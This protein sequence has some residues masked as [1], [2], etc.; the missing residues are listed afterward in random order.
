MSRHAAQRPDAG[1]E[2]H[3][4]RVRGMLLASSGV[5][6]LL[7]LGWA[8]FFAWRGDWLIVCSDAFLCLL[9]LHGARLVRQGRLRRAAL[10]LLP[11]LLL[12]V[13]GYALFL[14]LPTAAAPRTSHLYLLPIAILS[15]VIFRGDKPL[16]RHGLP[17]L[18]LLLF[19]LLSA[20]QFGIASAH[21]LPDSLR[22]P[23]S[24]I[25]SIVA[26]AAL[27]LVLS[28]LQ[29]DLTETSTQESALREG[30]M[31]SQFEL[32]YQPQHDVQG[33]LVGAEALV[34][35][36]HPQ[37][38]CI[39]PGE[40]V[41]LAERTGLILPLG[42]TVLEQ[43]CRQLAQWSRDPG[44]ADW[45]LAVN[46]SALQMQQPGFVAAVLG[47]LDY[48]GVA[49]SRLKLEL[50]EGVLLHDFEQVRAKM[51]ELRAAGIT[52]ALDDFGTGYSSLQ[53]LRQLPLQQIK[54]DKSF[55][56]ELV[57]QERDSAIVG[58]VIVLGRSL[59]LQVIAEGV[60][61]AEQWQR[62]SGL[63]CELFQGYWFSAPLEIADFEA[64]ADAGRLP[65]DWVPSGR[66]AQQPLSLAQASAG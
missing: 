61:N 22:V 62:L 24:W 47:L 56:A 48:H 31:R 51:H 58:T 16:L 25:T 1:S 14:D 11:G 4:R 23:G 2:Q 57:L 36:R 7:S 49:P 8:L 43:A 34:R 39:E 15:I 63:G 65:L 46:V 13:L 35:W 19:V 20:T 60:E 30:L 64:Y 17:L 3:Q 55:V 42:Q 9:A 66:Q 29:A 52:F 40:F 54:I 21:A 32:F 28:L 33:R 10:T 50:T 53:Y 45:S 26:T 6:L 59:G 5:T 41:P 18:L 44:K 27:V 12:V 38:G 37:H